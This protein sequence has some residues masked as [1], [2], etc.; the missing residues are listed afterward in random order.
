M[1]DFPS[2]HFLARYFAGDLSSTESARLEEWL[3][4]DATRRAQVEKLRE[5]WSRAGDQP[6]DERTEQVWHSLSSKL[7]LGAPATSEPDRV[8]SLVQH[9][10]P[11][12]IRGIPA[13]SARQK[14][15]WIAAGL[16]AAAAAVF[17]ALNAGRSADKAS[18]PEVVREYSTKLAQRADIRLLDG[19]RVALAPASRLLVPESYGSKTRAIQL[20]GEAYFDVVHNAAKPFTVRTRTTVARDIGTAFVVKDYTADIKADKKADITAD[21]AASVLVAEGEVAVLSARDSTAATLQLLKRG[22]LARVTA[23]GTVTLSRVANIERRL[24]WLRGGLAFDDVPLGDAVREIGRW[25][26]LDIRL[27]DSSL[28][29][30]RL[31]ATIG[32]EPADDVVRLVALTLGLHVERDGRVVT[33]HPK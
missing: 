26:D 1:P 20:E 17:F 6:S 5:L 18:S 9:R 13:F 3:Q 32:N 10:R 8:L 4:A 33:F 15:P 31:I 24:A 30:R 28:A 12:P 23:S 11:S 7:G 19:S 16:V 27:A 2:D 14:A 25:Y 21:I 22:D 29:R